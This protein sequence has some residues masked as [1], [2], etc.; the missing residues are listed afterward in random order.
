[1]ASETSTATDQDLQDQHR[2]PPFPDN[3]QFVIV[4]PKDVNGASGQEQGNAS[5]QP[6][7]QRLET[8]E[9][10]PESENQ[11]QTPLLQ[12]PEEI[13]AQLESVSD[14]LSQILEDYF[15]EDKQKRTHNPAVDWS[16]TNIEHVQSLETQFH[17]AGES[18]KALM[19]VAQQQGDKNEVNKLSLSLVDPMRTASERLE[20]VKKNAAEFNE[21]AYQH[22]EEITKTMAEL[23]HA[24]QG[25]GLESSDLDSLPKAEVDGVALDTVFKDLEEGESIVQSEDGK[26]F[27]LT[28]GAVLLGL[29]IMLISGDKVADIV[30][31]EVSKG[32]TRLVL[33]KVGFD[34]ETV[35]KF[36]NKDG[37]SIVAQMIEAMHRDDL[38]KY[39]T[40]DARPRELYNILDQMDED[41]LKKM[42]MGERFD[43]A[44]AKGER[45]FKPD[46]I[47]A[48]LG[49]LSKKEL[50]ELKLDDIYQDLTAQ[51]NS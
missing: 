7:D 14:E 47:K 44:F 23:T 2:V 26:Q 1:M 21:I 43:D 37:S 42:M 12:T 5:E 28:A 18:L 45:R 11:E 8:E 51:S 49:R 27:K 32:V 4:S 24:L 50:R 9:P 6:P 20:A 48:I 10:T 29:A 35:D 33:L 41:Q 25:L 39:L 15:P 13:K 17:Q 22:H 3:P 30:A 31:K 36:L 16:V 34:P 46:E 19:D 40:E 38:I